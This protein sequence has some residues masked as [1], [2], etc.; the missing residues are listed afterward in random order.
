MSIRKS[1]KILISVLFLFVLII[2]SK[3]ALEGA[4][5]GIKLCLYS[6]LPVLFPFCVLSKIIC[7]SVLGFKSHHTSLLGKITGIPS[8]SEAI[9][10][11]SLVGGYPIGAQCIDDAYQKGCISK[12]DAHR[13]LGF[14]NN[15]G[16]AF[17]FGI[18]AILFPDIMPLW[19]LY[20][21]HILTAIF[22]GIILPNKSAYICRLTAPK[23]RP[24]TKLIDESIR[25]MASVC[26][27]IV[28]FR[29]IL[30][31]LCKWLLC[32]L[33]NT[34]HAIIAGILE[35]SNG[36]ISLQ[37]L[38]NPGLK[39]ILASFFLAAGGSCVALQTISVT[40]H[41]GIGKYFEGKLL[42]SGLSLV[43]ASVAQHLLFDPSCIY[44]N[45][46]LPI[47]IGVIMSLT[48]ILILYK[49]KK[50]VAFV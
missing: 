40:Q 42:Q 44:S 38:D 7:N 3:T 27:W 32:Y 31:H 49:K 11:I 13:L 12:E 6:L 45:I 19:C 28:L 25:T 43:L 24:I 29:T 4:S 18:L 22:V 8:G 10:L 46:L 41:C 17:I 5:S 14:C 1:I 2:D 30:E 35:L 33:A 9:F 20:I 21:I 48:S 50:V 34:E 47:T 23:E 36:C 15:A 37:M 16:P 39:F 26:G